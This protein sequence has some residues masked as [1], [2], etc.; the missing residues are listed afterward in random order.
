MLDPV[1]FLRI[2]TPHACYDSD[3]RV[4]TSQILLKIQELLIVAVLDLLEFVLQERRV[5]KS[6]CEEALDG[7]AGLKSVLEIPTPRPP[8]QRVEVFAELFTP[9]SL[10]AVELLERSDMSREIRVRG[11]HSHVQE[12]NRGRAERPTAQR[13][14]SPRTFRGLGT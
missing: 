5:L 2:L 9:S 7:E 14:V 4:L 12:K 6:I 10:V 1:H 3:E 11:D 13:D 8:C